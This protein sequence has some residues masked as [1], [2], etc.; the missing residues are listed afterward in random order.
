MISS[1]VWRKKIHD[2]ISGF[3][4][5]WNG[6]EF[7][8][9][10]TLTHILGTPYYGNNAYFICLSTS[11]YRGYYR[12]T[13]ANRACKTHPWAKV[14][15]KGAEVC[16]ECQPTSMDKRMERCKGHGVFREE[17]LWKAIEAKNCH[18]KWKLI[19]HH[20][21]DTCNHQGDHDFVLV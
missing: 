9:I 19:T 1:I 12:V 17:T 7:W 8:R 15:E 6:Q 14:L 10:L 4:K 2:H 21:S 11:S 5:I 16:V 13:R 20:E 18:G 3:H